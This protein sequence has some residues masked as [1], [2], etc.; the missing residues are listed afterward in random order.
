MIDPDG[1]A[2]CW[3]QFTVFANYFNSVV[4]VFNFPVND[5]IVA[6]CFYDFIALLRVQISNCVDVRIFKICC[7]AFSLGAVGWFLALHS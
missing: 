3:L 6:Q 1:L 5:V 2:E 4:L 7:K